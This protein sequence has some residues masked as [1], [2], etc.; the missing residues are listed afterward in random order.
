M[1]AS[2]SGGGSGEGGNAAL[3]DDLGA[4]ATARWI[5]SR[6]LVHIKHGIT[7]R[8]TANYVKDFECILGEPLLHFPQHVT[9]TS[10]C[11]SDDGA[12]TVLFFVRSNILYP[13]FPFSTQGAHFCVGTY[14]RTCELHTSGHAFLLRPVPPCTTAY[15]RSQPCEILPARLVATTSYDPGRVGGSILKTT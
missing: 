8:T 7:L 11:R 15:D 13:Y 2:A 1:L 12:H 9:L 6:Y 4:A 3:A 10:I 14:D 5:V